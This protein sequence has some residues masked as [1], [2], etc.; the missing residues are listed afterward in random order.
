MSNQGPPMRLRF[1][2]PLALMVASAPLLAGDRDDVLAAYRKLQAASSY[3]A[4]MSGQSGKRTVRTEMDFVA[5]D[6]YRLE[7]EAG[8]QYVIG[9][10][11]V[12]SMQGHTMRVPLP[13]N[14][15]GQYRDPARL[16]KLDDTVTITADGSEPVDG[17]PARK[18]LFRDSRQPDASNTLWIGANGFPVQVRVEAKGTTTVVRYSRFNDPAIRIDPP[19]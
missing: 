6:R 3:H 1:L 9:D 12:M 14:L 13:K 18:Y 7:T 4:S 16:G 8:T 2:L 15:L 19:K 11:M 17:K 5:P 10:T